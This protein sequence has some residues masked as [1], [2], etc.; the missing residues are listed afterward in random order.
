MTAMSAWTITAITPLGRVLRIDWDGQALSPTDP[1]TPEGFLLFRRVND[2]DRPVR[3]THTGPFHEPTLDGEE[4]AVFVTA[5]EAT[6]EWVPR[7]AIQIVGD[8]PI[9]QMAEPGLVN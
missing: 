1:M 8:P 6:A 9:P 7:E 2:Q 3:A 5:Y 4:W